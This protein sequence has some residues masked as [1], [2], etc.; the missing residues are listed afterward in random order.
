MACYKQAILLVFFLFHCLSPIFR[1]EDIHEKIMEDGVCNAMALA[2]TLY[3]K[4][5]SIPIL[6]SGKSPSIDLSVR[7]SSFSMY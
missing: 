6:M 7:K 5:L 3:C 4:S 1:E 2:D